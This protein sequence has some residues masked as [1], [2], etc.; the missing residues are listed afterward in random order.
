MKAAKKTG[1]DGWRICRKFATSFDLEQLRSCQE[2][3][4]SLI[5]DRKDEVIYTLYAKQNIVMSS[6]GFPL[7]DRKPAQSTHT[8]QPHSTQFYRA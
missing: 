5:E 7:Q 2:T 6:I 1:R 3:S 4:D 8:S